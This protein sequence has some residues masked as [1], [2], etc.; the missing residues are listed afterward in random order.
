[1]KMMI[2]DEDK[3]DLSVFLVFLRIDSSLFKK[4]IIRLFKHGFGQVFF[5]N[6]FNK[7]NRIPRKN[8]LS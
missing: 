6:P 4:Q 1:M 5:S 8:Q 7:I 2:T 3:F